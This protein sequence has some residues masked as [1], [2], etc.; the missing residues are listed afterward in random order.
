MAQPWDFWDERGEVR[1]WN[2]IVRLSDKDFKHFE[3]LAG[4]DGHKIGV[5]ISEFIADRL[6]NISAEKVSA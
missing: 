6:A 4:G 1:Q 2:V 3:M 5:L